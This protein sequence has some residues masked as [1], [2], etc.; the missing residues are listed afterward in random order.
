MKRQIKNH[1][2][3]GILLALLFIL[4]A[5]IVAHAQAPPETAAAA[6][7]PGA[8]TVDGLNPMFAGIMDPFDYDTRGRRDPFIQPIPDRPMEQQQVHG[9]LLPLQKFDLSQLRLVGIIWDVKRPKAMIKDPTGY[10]HL[11]STN[12]RIGPRNGYIAVIREGE[13]VVVETQDQE[14]H[15]VSSAQVVKIAR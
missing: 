14:G 9:P 3:V 7:A 15:L 5:A 10:T 12:T 2:R 4:S 6:P 13:I 8:S 1:Q 11:V